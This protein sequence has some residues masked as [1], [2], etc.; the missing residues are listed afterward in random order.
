MKRVLWLVAVSTLLAHAQP[1]YTADKELALGKQLAAEVERRVAVVNDPAIS[2]YVDRIARKL[3]A[4]AVL[5]T[6]LTIKVVSGSNAY[7]TTLPG[8]FLD[9]DSKLISDAASEAELA[10]A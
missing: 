6:L 8:G 2:G 9:V 1:V 10:R 5:R 3:A 4:T 7:V